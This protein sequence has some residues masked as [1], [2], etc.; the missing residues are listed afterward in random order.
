[1]RVEPT[2]YKR[3]TGLGSAHHGVGHYIKQRVTA[4]AMLVLIPLFL[5]QFLASLTTGYDGVMAW[6]G[7]P[8]GLAV[9]FLN[10]SVMV[11]HMR[12]GFQTV[13]E[14]YIGGMARK[15]ALLLNGFFALALWLIALYALIKISFGG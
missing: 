14:D 4:I 9:T 15:I 7:S 13:I 11:V 1:M 2:P 3:V 12:L 8:F 5:F 6:L 10:V